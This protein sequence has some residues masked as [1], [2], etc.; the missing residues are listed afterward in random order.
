MIKM[1]KRTNKK[2]EEKKVVVKEEVIED[3]E[4]IG[5]VLDLV[6]DEENPIGDGLEYKEEEE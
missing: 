6:A 5:E 2:K 4:D 1:R 3:K